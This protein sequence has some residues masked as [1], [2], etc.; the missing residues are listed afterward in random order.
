MVDFIALGSRD[1]PHVTRVVCELE[2]LGVSCKVLDFRASTPVS[3]LQGED[4]S[5]RLIIDG[6]PL[7]E[8][9]VIWNRVKIAPAIRE[10]YFEG[11]ARSA[12]VRA[13]EWRATYRLITWLFSDQVFNSPASTQCIYKPFQQAMAAAAGFVVPR[14]LITNRK[15]DVLEFV[16]ERDAIL[17]SLSNMPVVPGPEEKR[18]SYSLL[19]LPIT[20]EQVSR[21]AEEQISSCPLFVQTNI[22]KEFELRVVVVGTEVFAFKIHSQDHALTRTDW[23]QVSALSRKEPCELSAELRARILRFMRDAGLFTGSLDLIVD[24]DGTVWFLEVNPDGQWLNF[25]S[26][27]AG[28]VARGFGRAF[29]REIDRAAEVAQVAPRASLVGRP[30]GQAYV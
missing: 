13:N 12:G 4:G 6:E 27:V 20:F 2:V 21:A 16:R 14:T 17:K 28:E 18:E 23:R 29:R 8:C 11:D 15:H 25:D 1:D 9:A 19:T 24:R 7:S 10:F 30:E 5:Y 26:L 3:I 22:P